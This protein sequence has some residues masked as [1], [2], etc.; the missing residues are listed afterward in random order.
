MTDLDAKTGIINTEY[1]FSPQA[2]DQ[3]NK[4]LV[5]SKTE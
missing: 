2:S 4:Y 1:R 3:M 5:K